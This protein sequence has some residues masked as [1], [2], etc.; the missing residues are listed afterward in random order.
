M[1]SYPPKIL[2]PEVYGRFMACCPIKDYIQFPLELD[3][4]MYWNSD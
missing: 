2:A 3:G 4:V 1:A